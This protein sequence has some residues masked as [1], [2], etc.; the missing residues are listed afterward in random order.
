MFG[1]MSDTARYCAF[2]FVVMAVALAVVPD[3][4]R[5]ME[6][7]LLRS[8]FYLSICGSAQSAFASG[9]DALTSRL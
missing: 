5:V 2:A 8:D 3:Y 4:A 6:S 9:W 1:C 7:E